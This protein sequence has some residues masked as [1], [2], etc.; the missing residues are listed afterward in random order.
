MKALKILPERRC[1]DCVACC[2]V[3]DVDGVKAAGEP[4]PHLRR[5]RCEPAGC[6]IY[7]TRPAPCRA[8]ACLWLLQW[9]SLAE[10]PDR[11]GVVLTIQDVDLGANAAAA[12]RKVTRLDLRTM[13]ADP[14]GRSLAIVATETAPG[15]VD[16]TARATLDAIAAHAPVFIRQHDGAQRLRAP[17]W[18]IEAV[19]PTAQPTKE[20][21]P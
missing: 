1:G 8:F 19:K 10:R 2:V 7:S 16:T 3:Y 5:R 13:L 15:A 20:P 6:D 17:R 18:W 21:T 12:N 11:I 9:G 14:D 4:C